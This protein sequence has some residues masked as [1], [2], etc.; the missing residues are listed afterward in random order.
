MRRSPLPRFKF[1]LA[2][3]D[4]FFN[5]GEKRLFLLSLKILGILAGVALLSLLIVLILTGIT[6]AEQPAA[7]V[8][9]QAPLDPT[10]QNLDLSQFRYRDKIEE[11]LKPAWRPWRPRVP[12]WTE[13][14]VD[15]FWI[16][17]QE[18]ELEKLQQINDNN[19]ERL[20]QKLR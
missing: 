20:L 11:L 10:R 3:K 1:K 7:P 19:L 12:R 8:L 2:P 6:R 16:A 13:E 18:I 9:S 5:E 14:M 17:P 4:L 15:R